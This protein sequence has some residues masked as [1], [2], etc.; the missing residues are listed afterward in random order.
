MT[1]PRPV[2]AAMEARDGRRSAWTGREDP[3][4]V[5]QH[6]RGGMGGR[7]NKHR[8]SNVVWLESLI[9]GAIESDPAMQ[10]EAIRRGI[11]ISLHADPARTPI[12]HAVHGLVVLD[13]AGGFTRQEVTPD[14]A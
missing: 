5:P 12:H 11:K 4:L 6:R 7:K 14:A 9:N 10:A 3:T 1:T 2:L 8:L 13:D